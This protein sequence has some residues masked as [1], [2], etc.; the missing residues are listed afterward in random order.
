M[1]LGIAYMIKKFLAIYGNH[2][3]ITVYGGIRPGGGGAILE[4]CFNIV[5]MST[6]LEREIVFLVVY[7]V[8]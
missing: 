5:L 6:L 7:L 8:K 2:N 4:I 1:K 3:F